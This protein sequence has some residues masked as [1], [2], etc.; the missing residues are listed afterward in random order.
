[1]TASKKLSLL[2]SSVL[3]TGRRTAFVWNVRNTGM[4][5]INYPKHVSASKCHI[6]CT[7][8]SSIMI[9]MPQSVVA[10]WVPNLKC[11]FAATTMAYRTKGL[12]HE[13]LRLSQCEAAQMSG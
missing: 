11:D 6:R 13:Q 10:G 12:A 8:V 2:L 1:M 7:R 5:L 9:L 4:M 3:M